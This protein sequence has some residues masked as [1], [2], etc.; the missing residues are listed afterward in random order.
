MPLE[1]LVEARLLSKEAPDQAEFDGLVTAARLKLADSQGKALSDES[2]FTLAYSASHSLALA[3]LRW[4]GYRPANK[5]YIVFQC[6]E[7]TAGLPAAKWRVLDKCHTQRNLAEY[8]G[9]VDITPELL[10]E[11]IAVT[12]E[13]LALVQALGPVPP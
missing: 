9:H 10:Q 13:L 2:R 6:L 8:Q 3:A 12:Q 5:R 4:H 11:L 1:N 7:Q